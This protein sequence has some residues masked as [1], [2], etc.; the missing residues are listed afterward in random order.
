MSALPPDKSVSDKTTQDRTTEFSLD[1]PFGHLSQISLGYDVTGAQRALG[2]T[3][4][5]GAISEATR[6]RPPE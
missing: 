4:E 2:G 5:A 6:R 3:S 1:R